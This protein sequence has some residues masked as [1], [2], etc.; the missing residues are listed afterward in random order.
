M[1]AGLTSGKGEPPRPPS[2]KDPVLTC[3]GGTG[4]IHLGWGLA[5]DCIQYAV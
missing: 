3:A 1:P 4:R 2:F 5:D